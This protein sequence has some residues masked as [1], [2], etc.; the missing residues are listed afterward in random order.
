MAW[1]V[2]C[3]A[4]WHW[5]PGTMPRA[6]LLGSD[7]V[8]SHRHTCRFF[9]APTAASKPRGHPLQHSEA[10]ADQFSGN[11]ALL[12]VEGRAHHVQVRGKGQS[13]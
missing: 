10:G 11:P 6:P 2:G 5:I 4:E 9:R 1:V 3:A 13:G 8:V 12:S 7:A